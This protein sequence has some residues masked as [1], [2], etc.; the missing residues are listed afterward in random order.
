RQVRTAGDR[1]PGT[2]LL[3]TRNALSLAARADTQPVY[4][5][6]P[7]SRFPLPASRFPLPAS[8]TARR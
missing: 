6:L 8:A 3:A 4:F 7:A 1:Q 2:V 5:A